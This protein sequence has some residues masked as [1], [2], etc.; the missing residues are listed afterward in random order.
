L[1]SDTVISLLFFFHFYQL[2]FQFFELKTNINSV[3]GIDERKT[4]YKNKN[5]ET[6]KINVLV[7]PSRKQF[8]IVFLN[9][10]Y[11]S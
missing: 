5:I 10:F 1:K 6:I 11:Y 9:V 7:S 8:S 3:I 4:K 2:I